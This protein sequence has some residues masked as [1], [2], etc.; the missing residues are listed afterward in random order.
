MTC[1]SLFDSLVKEQRKPRSCNPRL[2]D[3]IE[4]IGLAERTGRGI[5]RIYEGMLRD[6]R[7]AY[8]RCA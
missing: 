2:A 5:D 1:D 3:A 8:A 4:R 7:P 6:G